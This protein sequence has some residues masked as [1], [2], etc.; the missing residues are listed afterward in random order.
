MSVPGKPAR[1]TDNWI[2][3]VGSEYVELDCGY[4]VGTKKL[5]GL[6]DETTA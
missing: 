5:R 2:T 1:V 3:V 4:G 6:R